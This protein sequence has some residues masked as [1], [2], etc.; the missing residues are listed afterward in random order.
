MTRRKAQTIPVPR[1]SLQSLV[2]SVAAIKTHIEQTTDAVDANLPNL[3][4]SLDDLLALG[5]Y[6]AD[7]ATSRQIVRSDFSKIKLL[8]RG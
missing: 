3:Y 6:V 2:E 8:V 4:V 7:G 1:P 5:V